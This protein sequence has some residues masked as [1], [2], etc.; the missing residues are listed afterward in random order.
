LKIIVAYIVLKLLTYERTFVYLISGAGRI[1]NI[2]DRFILFFSR[3]WVFPI[4][5]L[6]FCAYAA[7]IYVQNPA[8]VNKKIARVLSLPVWI[9]VLCFLSSYFGVFRAAVF[10]VSSAILGALSAGAWAV[11][12]GEHGKSDD[13]VKLIDGEEES[14]KK[15]KV[16][17]TASITSIDKALGSDKLILIIAGLCA[18]SWLARHDAALLLILVP[19]I[20][21]CF[22]KLGS[23]SGIFDSA[24]GALSSLWNRIYPHVK[25]VV[26]ITVAG[27]LR[28]FVK[29]S[30]L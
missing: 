16:E 5:L 6:Y 7:W 12:N 19:F 17:D 25:K 10:G 21:A 29:V 28:Q 20:F 23:N 18:L 13:E 2:I 27:P 14:V 30:V 15:P 11:D 8:T 1:Y 4:I 24:H 3:A 9:Y 26:D 22:L